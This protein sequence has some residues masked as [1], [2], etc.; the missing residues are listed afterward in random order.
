MTRKKKKLERNKE[1]KNIIMLLDNAFDPDVRVYKEAK[2]LINNNFNV[3]ILCLDK[4][5]KYKDR[6]NEN[7]DGI[8]IKRFFCRT[9]KTT[10]LMGKYKIIGKFKKIVYF[11]W[12][13]KFIRQIKKYLKNEEFSILHCHDLIMAFC[14]VLFF[15]NKKIVFDMHEYYAN[16]K[17]KLL[18]W[19]IRKILKYTQKRATWII[20][21]NNFQVKDV[22]QREKLV[23]I[24]NYP[25]KEKFKN[26]NRV[27][28]EKFRISYTGYVR[29]YIPLLNLIKAANELENIEVS[30]NG[31]GDAYEKLKEEEGKLKNFVLTGSYNHDDI[32][33]F[34]EN[35]DMLYVVYNKENKNDETAFPTKFYEAMITNTPVIV[36][37]NTDMGD[38]VEKY[39]IGI[40]VD[41]TDYLD[42]KAKLEPIVNNKEILKQKSENINKI[43]SKFIWENIVRNLDKIYNS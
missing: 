43:S 30:I 3:K 7:I 40:T 20:H 22:K 19:I 36:S 39:D 12:L 27:N 35:S 6:E 29:H 10:K 28:S 5:N 31:S 4:K 14:G 18:N 24:P 32:A 17:N 11:W 21:V 41:G 26:F 25:Q 13:L 9:E 37:K 15:K 34:Y 2:Y 16:K 1:N 42:I 23:F 33:K 38:Y 8:I